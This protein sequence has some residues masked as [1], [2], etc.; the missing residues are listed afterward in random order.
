MILRLAYGYDPTKFN[1]SFVSA[2]ARANAAQIQLLKP[3]WLVE[4][5]PICTLFAIDPLW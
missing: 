2:V 3:G 5:I 1:E 4:S